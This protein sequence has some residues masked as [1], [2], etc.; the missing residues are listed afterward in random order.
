MMRSRPSLTLST[1]VAA[2]LVC[3]PIGA[4]NWSR[5]RGPNGTGVS[6][7]TA[8]PVEFG[9]DRN[10]VW[11]V[12]VPFGRSSPVVAGDRIF[13]TATEGDALVTLAVAR[14]TGEVLWRRS[15]ERLRRAD[16]YYG[17]DSSSSTPV[18]DGENVYAFFQESGVVSYDSQGNERWRRDLGPFR[19]FYGIAASPI[20][21]EDVLILVCDQVRGSFIVGLDLATGADRWRASRA[22]RVE[23]YS[24]PIVWNGGGEPALLVLG[25]RW[26]DAYDPG[27]GETLWS[28]SGIGVGPVASPALDGNLLFVSAPNHASEPQPP[29]SD[30]LAAHDADGDSFLSR[31]EVAETW[32][33]N[34]YG[35]VDMTGDGHIGEDDWE[36]MRQEFDS[37]AWGSYGI[38]LGGDEPEFLW[39][40]RQ[41]VPYIPSP[42]AYQGAVYLIK[43]SILTT[44]GAESGEILKRGRL[45]R[46]GAKIYASPV[47]AEGKV[48]AAAL[49][50]KIY[51][52]SGKGEWD[53]LATND[54]GEEIYATPVIADNRILV[55]TRERLMSFGLPASEAAGVE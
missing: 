36:Q 21:V 1:L 15:V 29:F 50:G 48:Y 52:L 37:D 26:I 19:N 38:R 46:D 45:G 32:M 2:G 24:T 6:E 44:V 53:I 33:K 18:T 39:N 54:L 14:Q 30:L 7:A 8:M 16:M 28:T 31:E 23:S 3:A 11:S 10:L 22:G 13:L 40:V 49:D 20:V 41:A 35:F 27:T 34:H 51:V 47:A 5:F 43:D 25:S 9:P 55:R 17:T 42:L 4:E 12:A